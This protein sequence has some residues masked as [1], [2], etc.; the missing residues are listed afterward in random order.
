[1]QIFSSMYVWLPLI[2]LLLWRTYTRFSK[3]QFYIATLMMI[4]LL[5]VTDSSTSYFFKNLVQRLRPCKMPEIRPLIPDF[6]Q[7]CG[8]KWGF[9]SAHSANSA[10]LLHFMSAFALRKK[11]EIVC[12]WIFVI[13]IGLSR[14]YLGV[15][16]PLDVLVGWSW[17]LTLAVL[18]KQLARLTLTEQVSA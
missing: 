13:L 2:A 3:R 9:F 4:L 10:A 18:W 6:S 5:A 16:F 15:H 8:G 12:C 17:G 1:M 7:G 11:F 14:I